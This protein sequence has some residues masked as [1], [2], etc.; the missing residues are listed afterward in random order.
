MHKGGRTRDCA[1]GV[2]CAQGLVPRGSAGAQGLVCVGEGGAGA[3]G[4]L[5]GRG[6][7]CTRA[8]ALVPSTPT[9]S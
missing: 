2:A 8:L 1:G 9:S 3:Q 6:G 4:L 7:G 5:R